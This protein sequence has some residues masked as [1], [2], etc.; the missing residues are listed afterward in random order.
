MTKLLLPFLFTS[1]LFA[2]TI[3][4]IAV[5][6][7]DEPITLYEFKQE[8]DI[9]KKSIKETLDSLIRLKLEELEAKKRHISVSNEE[10][11]DELK[12]MAQKNN[13]TLT[14]LYEAMGSA[15]NLT[16]SQI[17]QKTKERL[18][19]SK[20]FNAIAMS[21]IQEP[22]DEEVNEYYKLHIDKYKTAK[23]IDTIVYSSS[24]KQALLE[25][26][27]N[28]MM[29]IPSVNTQNITI[30]PSK[31]DQR[32]ASIILQ[33]KSNQFTPVLPNAGE[34]GYI[35]FYVLKKKDITTQPLESVRPQVENKIIEE[36]R[37]QVLSE[38]FQ[39]M[40]TN[41]DIKILRLPKE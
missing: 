12:K 26:M 16:E 5:T 2:G 34:N 19:K 14:Q 37:E 27:S 41:A 38:H 15:R 25:K 7:D 33:T 35:T 17:K 29:N 4:G 1:L 20:L 28:P 3:S 36:K 10:V 11:L 22:T 18:L 13:L 23:K 9:S 8:Q 32:V 30:D 6:I 40:R 31:I 39:R 21:Q 24:S